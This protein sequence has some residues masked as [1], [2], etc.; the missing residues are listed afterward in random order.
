M[1][2]TA[3]KHE[4]T[5]N[6]TEKDTLNCLVCLTLIYLLEVYTQFFLGNEQTAHTQNKHKDQEPHFKCTNGNKKIKIK[7]RTPLTCSKQC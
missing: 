4:N 3:H 7:Y 6:N 5:K 1:R 2:R